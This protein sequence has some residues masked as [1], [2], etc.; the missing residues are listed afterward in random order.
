M[1]TT[2]FFNALVTSRRRRRSMVALADLSD[3][4]LRDIGITRHDL[5]AANPQ[6]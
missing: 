4:Q 2:R 3:H 6:R 5:F 1:F